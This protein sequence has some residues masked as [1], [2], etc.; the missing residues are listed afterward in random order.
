LQAVTITPLQN[1]SQ[2]AGYSVEAIG[3]YGNGMPDAIAAS[4]SWENETKLG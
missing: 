1:T 4:D 2:G 3:D